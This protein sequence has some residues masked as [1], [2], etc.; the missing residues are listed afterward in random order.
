MLHPL[1]RQAASRE[2][3]AAEV[4]QFLT[5]LAWEGVSASIQSQAKSTPFS[6]IGRSWALSSIGSERS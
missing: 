4:E 3:G 5:R 2:I 6:S 1:S